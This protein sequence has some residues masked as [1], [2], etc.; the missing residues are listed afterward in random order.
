[1]I[2]Y[3]EENVFNLK[4]K[5]CLSFDPFDKTSSKMQIDTSSTNKDLLTN[6]QRKY[7]TCA[8]NCFDTYENLPIITYHYELSCLCIKNCFED[9]TKET[10]GNSLK[11]RS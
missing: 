8:Y 9:L 3:T 11:N 6:L 10:K 2:N 1:M 7:Y 4:T 5:K